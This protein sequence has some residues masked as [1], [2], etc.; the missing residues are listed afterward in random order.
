M[1]EIIFHHYWQSPVAEK[2]RVALGFLN[3]SWRSVEIPRIPPKPDLIALTGGYRR[4]PVL[5]IGADIFCDSHC[6][7]NRLNAHYPGKSLFATNESLSV[8]GFANWANGELFTHAIK[9]VLGHDIES[10]PKEFLADR[11]R[12][13]FGPDWTPESI[14]SGVDHSLSQ[15]QIMLHWLEQ[16]LQSTGKFITGDEPG[17]QDALCYYVIWFL[18]GR[19]AHGPALIDG[20]TG[21]C[22]WENRVQSY[23]QGQFTDLSSGEAI[24]IA[25][26]ATPE[27]IDPDYSSGAPVGEQVAVVPAG[28]GGDPEVEGKL[29]RLCHEEIVVQR[30]SSQT[31]LIHVHFP[32]TGYRLITFNA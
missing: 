5:Q 13:Y 16:S 22:D 26:Q 9:V 3:A 14:H 7:L 6:I 30:Q 24:E 31:D 28:D 29:V 21:V 23:G 12:L 17:L 27:P 32:R 10:L 15:C 11:A 19:Y 20:F 4:T 1:H 25:R 2:V 18:R 8:L